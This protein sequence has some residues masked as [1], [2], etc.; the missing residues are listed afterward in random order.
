M[1]WGGSRVT[2]E[3]FNEWGFVDFARCCLVE[4]GLVGGSGSL[5]V[6]W[7]YVVGGQV[8]VWVVLYYTVQMGTNEYAK[9]AA[10]GQNLSKS[11][12]IW[13]CLGV[14]WWCLG[15]DMMVV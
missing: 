9:G 1:A 11:E 7:W 8:L 5:V 3:S 10:R 12:R 14:S 13:A 2:A 4:S 15:D 6:V